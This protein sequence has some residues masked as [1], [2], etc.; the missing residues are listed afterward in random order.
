M[1]KCGLMFGLLI[2]V[3]IIASMVKQS[4]DSFNEN[5]AVAIESAIKQP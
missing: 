3:L 4:D 1:R 2:V 5:V